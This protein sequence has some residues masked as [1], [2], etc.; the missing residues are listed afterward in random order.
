ML[1]IFKP[2]Q[3]AKYRISALHIIARL[4]KAAGGLMGKTSV[5]LTYYRVSDTVMKLNKN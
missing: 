4:H 1:N 3:C 2:T 5:Y